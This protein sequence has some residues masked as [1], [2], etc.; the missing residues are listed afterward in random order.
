M[1][2]EKVL[3]WAVRFVYP[4]DDEILIID[5]NYVTVA[6]VVLMED[7]ELIVRAVNSHDLLL[8]AAEAALSWLDPLLPCRDG[9]GCVRHLLETAINAAKGNQ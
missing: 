1:S 7:A 5:K 4:T 8:E 3:P 6:D 2:D 9:C